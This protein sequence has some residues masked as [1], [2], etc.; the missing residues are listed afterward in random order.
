[1]GGGGGKGIDQRVG[2]SLSLSAINPRVARRREADDID[3]LLIT[4][5]LRRKDIDK[6]LVYRGMR[7]AVMSGR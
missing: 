1:M 4:A 7:S 2:I 6:A 5:A 3:I